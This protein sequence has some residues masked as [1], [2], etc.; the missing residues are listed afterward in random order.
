MTIAA[1]IPG[2]ID[3]VRFLYL[4]FEKFFDFF[5]Y[6]FFIMNIYKTEFINR[7]LSVMVDSDSGRSTVLY[8]VDRW[9]CVLVEETSCGTDCHAR[10]QS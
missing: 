5:I 10:P 4:F 1:N 8:C 9:H 6:F 7:K 2:S 3:D